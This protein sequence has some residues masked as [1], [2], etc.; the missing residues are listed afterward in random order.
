MRSGQAA[1][2]SSPVIEIMPQGQRHHA[3]QGVSTFLPSMIKG[4][5]PCHY[6]QT[7]R[8]DG[9]WHHEA[10][11][12]GPMPKRHRPQQDSKHKPNLMEERILKNPARRRKNAK[13]H[14][15]AD[16]M[17]DAHARQRNRDA[18]DAAI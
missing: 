14:C 6:A 9:R 12:H 16:A 2:S 15:G 4:H 17:R 7:Q 3:K 8:A 13:Q 11:F 10:M 1:L 18:I 5:G